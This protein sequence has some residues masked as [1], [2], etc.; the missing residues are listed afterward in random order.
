MKHFPYIK[1]NI[2]QAV[3]LL[4]III[5]LSCLFYLIPA[6][7][8]D[9][10]SSVSSGNV[11]T[12][13]FES[14]IGG[15]NIIGDC[16]A[17]KKDLPIYCVDIDS[18]QKQDDNTENLENTD[19][20]ASESSAA[21][22]N[23]DADADSGTKYIS[24]SFDAAWGADDTIQ[25]LDTLDKYNVKATFFMTGGWVDSF[26]D[27]VKEIYARGH[28]LGNHSQNHKQ[29]SKLSANEQK[30]E[31]MTVSDKIRE[32]TG[33]EVF[34]FRPPYGDYNST[35]I[36]TVYSCNHY[37]IQWDV[38]SLDWKDYGVENIIKTVTQHKALGNGSIILMHNGAKYTAEAL[39]TVLSTLQSQGY[40][41]VP[42]S[43]LIIKQNFHMD[44]TGRQ[45]AD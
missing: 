4:A 24:V 11:S 16:R 15:G 41:L 20:S 7:N 10:A 19:A 27:M 21:D 38:D 43:Q 17:G 42:V 13:K 14:G 18:K 44:A 35:L 9:N 33:Y 28:D 30:T 37:P 36:N 3:L 26:P 32:L 12:V 6:K 23:S 5:A 45:I 34:L 25:I 29:M 31:I 1:S 39:D 2:F 40:T 8:S 22:T